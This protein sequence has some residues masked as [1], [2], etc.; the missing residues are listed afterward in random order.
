MQLKNNAEAYAF[1][2]CMLFDE[3]RDE[4]AEGEFQKA[5][6]LNP[7]ELNARK[8]LR[9]ITEKRENENKGIFKKFFG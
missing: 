8:G 6:K 1:R 4:L 3:G 9:L 2:G 7:K 5:L